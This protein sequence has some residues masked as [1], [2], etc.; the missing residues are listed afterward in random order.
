M[1]LHCWIPRT[2]HRFGVNS[3]LRGLS[4]PGGFAKCPW[5]EPVMCSPCSLTE[6]SKSGFSCT[7][8]PFR[9]AFCLMARI[10]WRLRSTRWIS[11]I[12]CTLKKKKKTQPVCLTS[13]WSGIQ[14]FLVFFLMFCTKSRSRKSHFVLSCFENVRSPQGHMHVFFCA[15]ARC[16]FVFLVRWHHD[17]CL[18]RPGGGRESVE[19]APSAG[20]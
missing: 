19:Q 2:L 5:N 11:G 17:V 18:W 4:I 1:Q 6:I 3:S 9:D 15:G 12:I 10:V 14:I 8:R 20:M 7:V 13:W 16:V